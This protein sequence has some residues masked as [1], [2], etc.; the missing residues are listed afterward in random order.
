MKAKRIRNPTADEPVVSRRVASKNGSKTR[1]FSDRILAEEPL[2]MYINGRRFAVTMRTPGDDVPLFIGL[3]YAEGIIKSLDNVLLVK[4][5][6]NDNNIIDAR[7][8]GGSPA[9]KRIL[10]TNSSCGLCGLELIKKIITRPIRNRLRPAPRVILDIPRQMR[11]H[12]F[13]FSETGG[14]HAAAL[15]S[16]DGK[17]VMCKE[18]IGRHN[19]VDK[20]IGAALLNKM[21]PLSAYALAVSGRISFEIVQKA[22]KASIPTVC[23][24]SAASSLAVDFAKKAGMTLIGMIRGDSFNIY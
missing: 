22:Y 6:K 3:L 21:L 15:F 11:R 13:L 16:R 19:A 9:V 14:S 7:I 12:Q 8:K 10:I 2:E 18:D 4:H 1:V 17:L 5:C 24:V 20:L 23:S